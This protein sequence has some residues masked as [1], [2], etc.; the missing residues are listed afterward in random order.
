MEP[1]FWPRSD[2]TFCMAALLAL[3]LSR[4]AAAAISSAKRLRP[5]SSP[6]ALARSAAS[7]NDPKA[8]LSP[9]AG[10]FFFPLRT[11]TVLP[12]D[13]A[14]MSPASGTRVWSIA[15]S[16]NW[17]ITFLLVGGSITELD[18]EDYH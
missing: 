8:S 16:G 3:R 18:L 4:V 12:Y 9:R 10:P 11:R 5:T 14:W 13:G 17:R 7:A 15:A 2:A 6:A 1:F